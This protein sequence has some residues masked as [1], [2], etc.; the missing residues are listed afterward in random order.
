MKQTLTYGDATFDVAQSP[1]DLALAE[2]VLTH[3]PP[4]CLIELGTWIYCLNELI[5]EWKRFGL[6]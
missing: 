6:E 4:N 3:Y 2:H 1:A 5:Q